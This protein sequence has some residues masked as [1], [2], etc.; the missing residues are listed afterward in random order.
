[1]TSKPQNVLFI[2]SDQHNRDILG[3]NGHPIIQTPH[4]DKLAK[5]GVNFT[6][7][8]SNCPICVPSRASIATGRYPHDNGSWDN[9]APYS[10]DRPSWGH[11]LVNQ[12]IQVT[13][14]GKLHYRDAADDTG[15]LDQ[16]LPLHV[17]NGV[18]ICSP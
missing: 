2:M 13:T 6:N 12:G 16:R 15:F 1:M 11:R 17:L 14:V 3:H 7:A 5:D 9:A 4:L 10:G 18:G 8:Y